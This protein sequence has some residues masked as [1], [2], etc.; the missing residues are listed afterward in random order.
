M[1][2]LPKITGDFS[3]Y[4]RANGR[5][6]TGNTGI[7]SLLDRDG[8]LVSGPNKTPLNDA[9][10]LH[11]FNVNIAKPLDEKSDL[12]V[13]LNFGNY[14]SYVTN[15]LGNR[16]AGANLTQQTTIWKASINT[17]TNLPILGE[18]KL[19][20]GRVPTQFTPYTFKLVDPDTYVSNENTDSGNIPVDGVVADAKIGRIGVKAVI[21]KVDPINLVSNV[22]GGRGFSIG[23][24][25][26]GGSVTGPVGPS[27][28]PR[29]HGFGAGRAG[30]WC[31]PDPPDDPRYRH[32]CDGSCL[33]HP[34]GRFPGLRLRR[35]RHP[36]AGRIRSGGFLHPFGERQRGLPLQER[37]D[38]RLRVPLVR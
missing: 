9:R 29:S 38:R 37:S 13:R 14:L 1:A 10:A 5:G 28:Q 27:V 12:D 15:Q 11:D 26:P 25:A 4:A 22:N 24:T 8:Y 31:A 21:A 19:N 20:I 30:R 34:D 18:T 17:S 35:R 2:K 6:G 23:A 16:G 36:Q 7:S 3:V 33:R 32:H